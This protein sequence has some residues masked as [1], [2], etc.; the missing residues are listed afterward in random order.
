MLDYTLYAFGPVGFIGGFII[1]FI[2]TFI[3]YV[4]DKN[5]RRTVFVINLLFGWLGLGY[6]VALLLSIISR[7]EQVFVIKERG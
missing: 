5:D 6:C 1:Y 4:L 2:P 3:A 7:R